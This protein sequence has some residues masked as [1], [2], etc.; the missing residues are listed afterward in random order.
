M[1]GS[2]YRGPWDKSRK[3]SVVPGSV[4]HFENRYRDPWDTFTGIC[5]TQSP[6]P[7]G[8][9]YRDLW[10][11]C[12]GICGTDTLGKSLRSRLIL[13]RNYS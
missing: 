8:R 9:S 12:T 1:H 5:G 11:T 13:K 7:V 2:Q 4:G 3:P 10:D 6:G